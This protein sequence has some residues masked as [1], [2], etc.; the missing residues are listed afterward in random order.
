MLVL[1]AVG[2]N[3]TIMLIILVVLAIGTFITVYMK[4]P[5]SLLWK[6]VLVTGIIGAV[7]VII[8]PGNTVRASDST[9]NHL[10]LQSLFNSIIWTSRYLFTWTLDVGLLSASLLFFR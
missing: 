3:E 4:H 6:I 10:F 2:S 8:A 9:D 7:I 1:A 5:A